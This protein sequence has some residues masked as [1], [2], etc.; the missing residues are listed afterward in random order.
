MCQSGIDQIFHLIHPLDLQHLHNIHQNYPEERQIF[1]LAEARAFLAHDFGDPRLSTIQWQMAFT[2][3]RLG[4]ALG[5]Q[6]GQLSA[7]AIEVQGPKGRMVTVTETWLPVRH[8]WQ[9]RE[10]EGR[11][12]KGPKKKSVGQVPVPPAVAEMMRKLERGS[13]F[14][15]PFLYW[16]FSAARPYPK[17]KVEQSYNAA[18]R[19]IGITDAERKR[20]G[21][22]CHAWRH[23]YDTHVN[24]ERGVLQKL[25]RHRSA[26]M[27]EHYNHLTLEQRRAAYG[28]VTGLM[29]VVSPRPSRVRSSG[30]RK[31]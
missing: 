25:M 27:T 29:G 26:E 2:G 21:L 28:A 30:P 13:P 4:E 9:E 19:A 3:M 7:E 1:T 15:G 14:G 23:W 16:G 18:C 12:L 5:T 31:A 8:N 11:R 10:P 24:V 17:D 6:H 20:R 22:G